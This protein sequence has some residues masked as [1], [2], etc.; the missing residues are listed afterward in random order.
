MVERNRWGEGTNDIKV[1]GARSCT[2]DHTAFAVV[3]ATDATKLPQ[4]FR[5]QGLKGSVE[6]TPVGDHIANR[7]ANGDWGK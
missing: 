6:I 5:P 1:I 2:P 7:K 4:S 3:E